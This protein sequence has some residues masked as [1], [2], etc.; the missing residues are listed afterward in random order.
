MVFHVCDVF[1]EDEINNC[2]YW[3][4]PWKWNVFAIIL[5]ILEINR[6]NNAYSSSN[7]SNSS[8]N[9]MRIKSKKQQTA[10]LFR[11]E[12]MRHC[13]TFVLT[14][15]YAVT[16]C[17]KNTALSMWHTCHGKL[18]HQKNLQR[19]V[20]NRYI[21]DLSKFIHIFC[22]RGSLHSSQGYRYQEEKCINT[23]AVA[24]KPRHERAKRKRT[25]TLTNLWRRLIYP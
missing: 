15:K 14:G 23:D 10:D 22:H 20:G 11:V 17:W 25:D 2:S 13:M 1:E 4:S 3:I 21:K 7:K 18:H 19:I 5:V 12:N 8:S 9:N 16:T 6:F 24:A